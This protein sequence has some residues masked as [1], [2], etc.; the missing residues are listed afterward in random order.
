ML[1]SVTTADGAGVQEWTLAALADL[2]C[3]VV[4]ERLG[5]GPPA[6]RL[7]G[8]FCLAGA[9]ADG[10]SLVGGAPLLVTADPLAAL[11]V[12]PHRR[13]CGRGRR[14]GRLVRL[15]GY[16]GE[17]ALAFHDHVLRLRQDGWHFEAL[18][19]E[20]SGRPSC[21]Q[22][23]LGGTTGSVARRARSA[24]SAARTGPAIS[25]RWSRRWPTSGR[26]RFTR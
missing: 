6:S 10:T 4:S 21:P 23:A 5:D 19:S 24:R 1:C 8:S 22:P 9:W 16:D 20:T 7:A 26:V 17:C 3:R 13:R 15:A 12:Q 2:R 11:S 25:A 18:W 14:R